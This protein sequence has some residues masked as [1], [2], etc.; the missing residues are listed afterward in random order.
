M[1]Y[2]CTKNHPP[3]PAIIINDVQVPWVHKVVQLAYKLSEDIY[4]SSALLNVLK[5]LIDNP[6]ISCKF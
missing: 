4:I 6:K 1:I 2:K 3:D 5:I